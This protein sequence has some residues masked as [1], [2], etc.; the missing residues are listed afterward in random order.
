MSQEFKQYC[1]TEDLLPK[2]LKAPFFLLKH[3][4]VSGIPIVNLQGHVT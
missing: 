3:K 4:V 2:I 1:I